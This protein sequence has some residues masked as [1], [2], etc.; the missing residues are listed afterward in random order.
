MKEA[1]ERCRDVRSREKETS[2]GQQG[3]RD[4]V[5][6]NRVRETKSKSIEREVE[7]WVGLEGGRAEKTRGFD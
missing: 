6:V 1:F 7:R 3:E 2:R 5:E 4:G